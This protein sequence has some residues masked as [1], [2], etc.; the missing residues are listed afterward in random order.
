MLDI[1]MYSLPWLYCEYWS[2]TIKRMIEENFQ[3]SRS[4]WYHVRWNAQLE[5]SKR[6]RHCSLKSRRKFLSWHEANRR[7]G[8][9]ASKFSFYS[10]RQIRF[11]F[12]SSYFSNI[13]CTFHLE[14]MFVRFLSIIY[15]QFLL[16]FGS[17]IFMHHGKTFR[18]HISFYIS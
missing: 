15:F 17:T 13:C 18:Q 14:Q 6:A 1:K 4:D 8:E 16:K 11:S 12:L 9:Q 7:A 3:K 2:H 10:L 5:W